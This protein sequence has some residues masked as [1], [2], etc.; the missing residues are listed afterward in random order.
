MIHYHG[1]PISGKRTATAEFLCGRHTLIPFARQDDLDL[2]I[3]YSSS[4][5]VDN[6]AY[7]AHTRGIEIDWEEYY[8][9]VGDLLHIPNFDWAII[10]DVIGGSESENDELLSQYPNELRGVPVWHSNESVYRLERLCESY[11]RVAIGADPSNTT[12]SEGWWAKIK[13]AMDMITDDIGRVRYGCRLHGLRMLNPSIFTNIPLS[14]GDSA[15]IAR[16][17]NNGSVSPSR[18][19][20]LTV[21]ASRIESVNA[22]TTWQKINQNTLWQS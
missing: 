13:P 2:A 3:E 20:R 1:T 10:P 5:I 9:W 16:N 18:L 6:S 14:S 7:S 12:G 15:S 17:A 19:V 4:F 22:A 8:K 11:S 21:L